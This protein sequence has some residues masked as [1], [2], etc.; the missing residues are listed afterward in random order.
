[1]VRAGGFIEKL[2][3]VFTLYCRV[4]NLFSTV[5][6]FLHFINFLWLMHRLLLQI[7]VFEDLFVNLCNRKIE[8]TVSKLLPLLPIIFCLLCINIT[9]NK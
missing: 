7:Y 8:L 5:R 2:A 4:L 3:A 1:M 6:T 9:Y